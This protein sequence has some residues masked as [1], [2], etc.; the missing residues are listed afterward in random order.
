MHLLVLLLNIP[1]ALYGFWYWY[2]VLFIQLVFYLIAFIGLK[3]KSKNKIIK[4]VSYYCMTVLAQW[5]GVINIVTGKA[6]PIWE[7]ADSTR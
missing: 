4:I 7:K 1:L 6:K 2:I 5:Q 3:T